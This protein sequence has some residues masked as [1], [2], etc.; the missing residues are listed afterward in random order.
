MTLPQGYDAWRT[1]GPEEHHE[2]GTDYGETC[3]RMQEPDE[4]APRGYKP[5]P[6]EGVMDDNDGVIFCPECGEIA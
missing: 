1:A 6:C 5:K 4:D 2:V 3:G